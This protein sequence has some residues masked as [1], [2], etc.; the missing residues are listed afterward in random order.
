MIQDFDPPP[1]VG[2]YNTRVHFYTPRPF[3]EG[4]YRNR[5]SAPFGLIVGYGVYVENSAVINATLIIKL[6]TIIENG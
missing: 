4:E 5:H 1:G 2:G 3:R 6:R